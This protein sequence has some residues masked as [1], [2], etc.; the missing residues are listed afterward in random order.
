MWADILTSR[1]A[2]YCKQLL[3]EFDGVQWVR[4]LLNRIE[5]AGGIRYESKPLL[6][7]LRFAYELHRLGLEASYEYETGVGNSTVDFRVSKGG[8]EWLIELVS[9]RTSDAVKDATYKEGPVSITEL[10]SD[11]ADIRQSPEA[12]MIRAQEKIIEKVFVKDVGPIKFPSIQ[13]DRYHVIVCDTRGYLLNGGDQWDYRQIAYGHAGIPQSHPHRPFLVQYWTGKNGLREPIKGLFEEG[14]PTTGTQVLQDRMHY[15]G[16]VNEKEYKEGYIP[17]QSRY[18][19][20][21]HFFKRGEE[22]KIFNDH[23]PLQPSRNS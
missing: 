21:W 4:P 13:A 17:N 9:L 19:A 5:R 2:E 15:L 10:R 12:A 8:V 6:F 20:N 22:E 18:F 23:F 11:A 3:C 7:E 1:E 16:F 14:N